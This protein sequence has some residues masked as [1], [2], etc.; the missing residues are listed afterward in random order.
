M[1][2]PHSGFFRSP[3]PTE[4]LRPQA[5]S[6]P[7]PSGWERYLALLR[8]ERVPEHQRRWYVLRAEAFIAAVRPTRM[9]QVSADQVTAFLTRYPREHRLTG[10]Q[11]RQLV[12][13]LQWLLVDLSGNE[14]AARLDWDYWRSAGETLT[15]D[16]PTVAAALPAEEAVE[17]AS[18]FASAAEQWPLLKDMA[19]VMRSRR[20]AIRTEQT[21]LDWC[22]RFLLFCRNK[23]PETVQAADVEAFLTHL[24]VDRQVSVSTQSQALNALVFLF[25][26]VLKRT[27]EQMQFRYARRERKVPVVLS[28][29]ELRSLF[30]RLPAHYA[31]MARLMYGT[32]MRLM[33][34]IRLRV[35]DLDFGSGRVIVRSGKGGKDRVVPLPQRLE[36]PLKAHLE[37]V[38]ALHDDDLAAGVGAVSLPGA[39]ARKSPNAPREW[40]WQYVFPSPNLSRDPKGGAVRRQH[41]N[42]SGLQRALKQAGQAAGIAKRVNSHCLRHSFATHLLQAGYDIRTVQELLGHK[43]VSTT[44]IYT[45]VLNRPGVVPVKSP[46]DSL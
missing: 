34:A 17:Q 26:Y 43:D 30:E 41:L 1:P 16:H 24:A 25:R 12:D 22:H 35:G 38:K 3:T 37:A 7:T 45:H 4:A 39:L 19:R 28:A 9:R 33:E 40:V 46:V 44:M 13:A 42:E 5:P 20:Y 14:A 8:R 27:P 2:N 18:R 36:V 29:D 15:A 11:F 23:P 21:Y 6:H 10:W 31:L 32:G